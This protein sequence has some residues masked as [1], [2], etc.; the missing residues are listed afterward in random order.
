M[1]DTFEEDN[2][3]RCADSIAPLVEEFCKKERCD[4]ENAVRDMIQ[5]LLHYARRNGMDPEEEIDWGTEYFI[6]DCHLAGEKVEI[7]SPWTNGMEL[8]WSQ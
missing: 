3:K 6:N 5:Y 8:T 7:Q 1:T 2:R 4:Q